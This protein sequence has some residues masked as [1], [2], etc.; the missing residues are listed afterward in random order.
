MRALLLLLMSWTHRRGQWVTPGAT[1][2]LRFVT[3]NILAGD[4][5][6]KGIIDTL[7]TANADVIGLQEVDKRTKRS[8][9]KDEAVGVVRPSL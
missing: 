6:L 7:S 4:R 3:Y 9:K 5:G 1:P 2:K 8:G